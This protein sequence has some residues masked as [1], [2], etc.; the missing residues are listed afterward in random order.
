MTTVDR[1]VPPFCALAVVGQDLHNALLETQYAVESGVLSGSL[2]ICNAV[3]QILQH[4]GVRSVISKTY[5]LTPNH[6]SQ[7]LNAA[8]SAWPRYSGNP[9]YPVPAPNQRA[10]GLDVD[11]TLVWRAAVTSYREAAANRSM[12]LADTE[13]GQ[14]RRD[15]L[16][17][18]TK[19][20]F[21]D[22]VYG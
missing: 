2:G 4:G 18:L 22:I 7:L 13:Y 6:V 11:T 19:F 5:Y 14:L 12:W 15:L 16:E 20:S 9:E 8:F 10:E 3:A 1:D 21:G 17:H